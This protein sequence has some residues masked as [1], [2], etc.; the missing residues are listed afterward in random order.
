MV[1][2]CKKPF[3]LLL[4]K[5]LIGLSLVQK[6]LR[7]RHTG[8]NVHSKVRAQT[9]ALSFLWWPDENHLFYRRAETKAT[10]F[11]SVSPLL[12]LLSSTGLGSAKSKPEPLKFRLT[13]LTSMTTGIPF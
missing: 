8:F 4:R 13:L 3:S 5:K 2:I 10:A 12:W 11:P 1:T 7:W 9:N 6:I